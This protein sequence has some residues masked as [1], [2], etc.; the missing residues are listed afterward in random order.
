MLKKRKKQYGRQ[1]FQ[2]RKNYVRGI[3]ILLAIWIVLLFSP[4]YAQ[5]K[6]QKVDQVFSQ[7]F[8]ESRELKMV[9][10]YKQDNNGLILEFAVDN[11]DGTLT[12]DLANLNYEV[13][14]KTAKGDYQSIKHKFKKVTDSFFVLEL[15]NV[16]EIY[17]L[18]KVTINGQPINTVIDTQTQKDM[19]YYLHQDKV[20]SSIGQVDYQKEAANHEIANLNKQIE[21]Q[22][23][24]IEKHQANIRLNG[25]LIKKLEKEM[26]FQ[27]DEEKETSKVTIDNYNIENTTLENQV[28]VAKE[29]IE[30]LKEKISLKEEQVKQ[31]AVKEVEK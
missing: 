30:K 21:T 25:Q 11:E 5:Q 29:K 10:R 26:E 1:K 9:N 20:D 17:D 12:K 19:I 22:N 27:T 28:S 6:V 2:S 14:V 13:E 4:L 8:I 18:M 7:S 3:S 16:P 23:K 15:E 24:E 31:S